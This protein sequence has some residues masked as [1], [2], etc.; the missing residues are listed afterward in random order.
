MRRNYFY[1]LSLKEIYACWSDYPYGY[2]TSSRAILSL[3][4]LFHKYFLTVQKCNILK[5][6]RRNR[7]GNTLVPE[8]NGKVDIS[9]KTTGN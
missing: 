5:L 6:S 1:V 2:T 3:H 4:H 7:R 9:W 8:R